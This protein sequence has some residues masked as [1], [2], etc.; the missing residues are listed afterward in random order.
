MENTLTF[1]QLPQAVATL[2]KE[3]CELKQL[4]LQKSNQQATPPSEQ[5][6]TV[7]EAADFLNLSVPTIYSKVSR[8]E[9]PVMKRG[10][11]LHFSSTELMQYL[12]DGRKHTNSEIE[13]EADNFLQKHR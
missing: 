3:V 9:L 12:K 10:K 4:L 8:G 6:L 11:K 13:T 1:D 7:K 5:L 2:T